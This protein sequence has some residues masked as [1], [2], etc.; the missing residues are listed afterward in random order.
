MFVLNDK[1]EHVLKKTSEIENTDEFSNR[2]KAESN[3]TDNKS[4]PDLWSHDSNDEM[5]FQE[6]SSESSDLVSSIM[7]DSELWNDISDNKTDSQLPD[8]LVSKQF[9]QNELTNEFPSKIW[10]QSQESESCQNLV[11]GNH[12]NSDIF[13]MIMSPLGNEV[14]SPSAEMKDLRLSSPVDNQK[15]QQEAID[16]F[17]PISNPNAVRIDTQSNFNNSNINLSTL[18]S[19]NEDSLK[20]LLN[21]ISDK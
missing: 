21:S 15:V 12:S 16:N 8:T 9:H 4:M 5:K 18:Q 6:N 10:N 2:K 20:E 14:S 11:N 3:K 17:I 7:K 1:G 13:S 19:I